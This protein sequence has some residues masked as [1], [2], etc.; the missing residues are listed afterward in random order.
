M[1]NVNNESFEC[2]RY[3]LD[4]RKQGKQKDQMTEVKNEKL[5]ICFSLIA[6]L[7]G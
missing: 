5:G 7:G 4:K 3:V 1:K 2:F 6:T